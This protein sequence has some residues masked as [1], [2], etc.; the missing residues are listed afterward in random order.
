MSVT[1]HKYLLE[2]WGNKV[3][4]YELYDEIYWRTGKTGQ[5]EKASKMNLAK[6]ESPITT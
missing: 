6:F 2:K 3:K 4:T 1:N 5:Q